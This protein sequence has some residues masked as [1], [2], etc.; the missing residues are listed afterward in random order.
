MYIKVY[1]TPANRKE[2]IEKENDTT[3]RIKVK[4]PALRNLANGRIR[5]LLSDIHSL[6][7]EKVRLVSGHRSSVKVFD[8]DVL[9][10]KT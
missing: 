5:E 1:A 10:D 9:L 3:Y 7:K 6:S 2:L 4:E 8:V